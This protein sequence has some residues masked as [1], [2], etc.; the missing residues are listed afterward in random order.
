MLSKLGA[1]QRRSGLNDEAVLKA[2]KAA[3]GKLKKRGD[4]VAIATALTSAS[5][6][7]PHVYLSFLLP[8]LSL[9]PL[10]QFEIHLFCFCF[11][12]T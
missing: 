5:S 9:F 1:A 3:A 6:S 8:P 10:L 12:S 2:A 7:H 4:V 11:F